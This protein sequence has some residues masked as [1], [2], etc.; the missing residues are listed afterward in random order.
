MTTFVRVLNIIFTAYIEK[1]YFTTMSKNSLPKSALGFILEFKYVIIIGFY[2][3]WM[4]FMDN[5]NLI[6]IY[7]LNKEIEHF[8]QDKR[9]YEDEIQALTKEKHLM[10]ND[11]ETTKNYG[12][13]HMIVAAEGDDVFYVEEI[14]NEDQKKRS[15]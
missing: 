14:K 5:N 3:F 11:I 13:K 1:T 7:K 2:A 6:S 12:R 10:E 9:F 15:R 8:E 4:M